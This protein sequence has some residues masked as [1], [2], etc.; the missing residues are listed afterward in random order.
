MECCI[1][2]GQDLNLNPGSNQ[3]QHSV[4]LYEGGDSMADESRKLEKNFLDG[5]VFLDDGE[6]ERARKEKDIIGKLRE[7]INFNHVEEVH[8]I[9]NRLL[10]RKYFSTAIGMEFLRDMRGYLMEAMGEEAVLPIPVLA[11]ASTLKDSIEKS[12]RVLSVEVEKQNEKLKDENSRL[13]VLKNRLIIAVFALCATV[14][15][16]IFIIITNENVGYFNAEEKILNK[17]SAWQEQLESWEDELNEREE[18][19]QNEIGR[20]KIK[21]KD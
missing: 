5:Y 10:E 18:L 1:K 9:Y 8:Q 14:I 11:S 15:G 2:F 20:K 12:R 13:R 17:Y 21:K 16:M 3:M 4:C 19:L 7:S 6:L